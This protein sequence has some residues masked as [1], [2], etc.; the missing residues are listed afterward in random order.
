MSVEVARE[1]LWKELKRE[2]KEQ[3]VKRSGEEDWTGMF[4]FISQ[5]TDASINKGRVEDI[6]NKK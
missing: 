2:R 6:N 4:L 3:R 5:C 1:R